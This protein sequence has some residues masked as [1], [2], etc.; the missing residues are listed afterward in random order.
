M[1]AMIIEK[2]GE[3]K[4][5]SNPLNYKD[6]KIP[7]IGD[8]DLLI[9]VVTCGVCHTEIDEIEG[10]TPPLFLPIVPGH[11]IVGF[12]EDVGKD[13]SKFSLGDRVGIAWIN[14]SCGDCKHCLSGLENLCESF[15]ATGRDVNGGYAEYT[16]IS[17]DYA[18]SIPNEIELDYAA[19]LLCAGAI[20]YRSLMLTNIQDNDDIGL[21]GFGASAHLVLKLLKILYPSSS[22]YVFA[23]SRL[24]RDFAVE[25]GAV[26]A[27]DID[28]RSPVK[29]SS[30][31]DTTPV[32]R[33]VVESLGNLESGGRLVVNAIRKEELDKNYLLNI[34]YENHL[35]MEKE[36]KSVANVSRNDV[37]E[38]LNISKDNIT[39][40]PEVKFY[41][42]KDANLAIKDIKMGDTVGSK[43]IKID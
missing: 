24:Q 13:V 40:M 12:V 23:R 2:L 25:L 14:S 36:I 29:L 22:V 6:I 15:K 31:I 41:S 5:D 9:K 16:V 26:W 11:Q 42:L 17:E 21:M 35:W 38:F 8:K 1:R 7:V 4:T 18:I 34:K 39:L 30:I 10:R 37:K 3:I 19:P 32:W 43:V 20:G 27:G 28:S 33:P